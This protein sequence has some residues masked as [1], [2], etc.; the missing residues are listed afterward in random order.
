MFTNTVLD[1]VNEK[2]TANILRINPKSF[3]AQFMQFK[4]H[5]YANIFEI[6]YS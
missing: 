6:N 2:R 1:R 4:F 5:L 3:G